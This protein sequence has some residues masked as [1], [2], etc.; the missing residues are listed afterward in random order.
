MKLLIGQL[1]T[2]KQTFK[3]KKIMPVIYFSCSLKI[4]NRLGTCLKWVFII[5]FLNLIVCCVQLSLKTIFYRLSRLENSFIDFVLLIAQLLVN[6][7]C[8]S[9]DIMNIRAKNMSWISIFRSIQ[10]NSIQFES[11]S[12]D[13]W[14]DE[15]QGICS[16]ME[17]AVRLATYYIEFSHL[18]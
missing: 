16:L 4:T 2:W 9:V 18:P 6:V 3:K 11:S 13:K 5:F 7:L 15:G 10:F 8:L 14:T 12:R 17:D 1:L